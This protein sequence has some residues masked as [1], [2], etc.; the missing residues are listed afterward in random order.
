MAGGLFFFRVLARFLVLVLAFVLAVLN[1]GRRKEKRR[2][3]GWGSGEEREIA[4]PEL[5]LR[6]CARYLY[7]RETGGQM[8]AQRQIQAE[9]PAG[10]EG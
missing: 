7:R 10:E 8:E 1:Q 2:A 6:K 9:R 5:E 4:S 3:A